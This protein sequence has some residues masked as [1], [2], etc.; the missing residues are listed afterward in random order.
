ME[1]TESLRTALLQY[2]IAHGLLLAFAKVAFR[3]C[4]ES[5]THYYPPPLAR[6]RWS[7]PPA[8]RIVS[9]PNDAPSPGDNMSLRSLRARLRRWQEKRLEKRKWAE[10]RA[11][12]QQRPC[13][14]VVG[15]GGI[16]HPGWLLTDRDE[17]DLLQDPTWQRLFQT[18]SIQAILAEHVWEH[19]T[20]DDGRTA[21]RQCHKYLA[22]GGYLRLA[23]PDGNHPDEQYI[24]WVK[25]NGSGAGAD[26]HKV[27]YNLS[28]LTEVLESA[29]FDVEPLEHFDGQGTFHAVDWR[30]EDGLV[31]RSA[32][33]DDRNRDGL[34]Y[35][36]LI[37]DARKRAA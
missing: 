19:L 27:L 29:G 33:F 18:D 12:A 23:V 30:P 3:L 37:V 31:R 16:E 2:S 35:T 10:L 4:A 28:S 17:V 34:R 21:A 9:E 32:R 13:R 36:S 6:D 26:D 7:F 8:I 15:A 5:K 1:L 14:V 25:P 11:L 24:D 20:P 22:P